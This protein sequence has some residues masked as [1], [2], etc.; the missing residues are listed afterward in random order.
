MIGAALGAAG[1]IFGGIKASQAMKG[2]QGNL[3]QQMRDNQAWYERNYNDN[4]LER[5][6]AQNILSQ[7]EESIR[8]RNR[9][10]AGASAV[11]GASEESV[12]AQK[13]AGNQALDGA[14]RQ[15]GVMDE[16]RKN[17]VEN[18]YMQTKS[19]LNGQMN[20]LAI[21]KAENISK[22]IGGVTDAAGNITDA[23]LKD[24]F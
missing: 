12:A 4:A 19:G 14:V 6:S 1:S 3:E 10:A 5:K 2:V 23:N 11:A 22:A 20:D 7:T 16:A 9:Q 15:I 21:K 17:Q 8:N 18:Q 24:L 13:A